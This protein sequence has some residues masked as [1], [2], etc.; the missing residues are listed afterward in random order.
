MVG[1]TGIEPANLPVPNR[2]LYAAELHPENGG[3]CGTRTHDLSGVNR[4]SLLLDELPLKFWCA[5]WD[6]DP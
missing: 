2:A 4:E 5:V 3:E 6:S 1:V